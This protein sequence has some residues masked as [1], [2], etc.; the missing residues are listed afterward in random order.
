MNSD[1]DIFA[2]LKRRIVNLDLLPGSLINE[3]EL[4]EEFGYSRTP[5]REA[6][7]KLAQI[8]LVETRPRVGTYVTQIDI[9]SVKNAYE[10]KKNLEGLA[11][12]LAARRAGPR[13]VAEL[14]EIIDRFTGYDIIADYKQCID[15]DQRFHEIVRQ[16]ARND[17]LTEIL[18]MLNTR[19]ARFLQ[20]IQYV[21][22]D[23]DW[24]RDSLRQMARA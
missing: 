2:V 22:D 16:A 19:T 10:V 20:Q 24:F 14:F 4:M 7:I 23:F 12:E 21:I 6:L 13:E 1:K 15:D 17:L 18:E 9:M 8:G 3:K 11:A 5:V